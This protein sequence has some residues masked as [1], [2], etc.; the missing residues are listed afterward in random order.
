MASLCPQKSPLFYYE[1]P[2]SKRLVDDDQ[3]ATVNMINP[4]APVP[5]RANDLKL[6]VF[7]VVVVVTLPTVEM[8]LTEPSPVEE[9]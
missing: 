6:P 1:N 2:V 7:E 5:P 8:V 3:N 9:Y 4:V